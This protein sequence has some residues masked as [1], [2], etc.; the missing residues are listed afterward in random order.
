MQNLNV[1]LYNDEGCLVKEFESQSMAKEFLST[2]LSVLQRGI[3]CKTKVKG[4]YVSDKKMEK[5]IKEKTEKNTGPI[6]QYNLQGEYLREFKSCNFVAKYYN[7][8]TYNR[9]PQVIR[10]GLNK[11]GDYL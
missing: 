2:N 4:Y 7:S 6:Y 8:K 10:Q 5:F 9:I 11:C 3:I 1:Y